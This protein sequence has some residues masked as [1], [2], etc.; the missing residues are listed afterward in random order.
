V[1]LAEFGEGEHVAHA[2]DMARA[3]L[4]SGV[5]PLAYGAE[6]G[7]EP[8][9]AGARVFVVQLRQ[10]LLLAA[11]GPGEW[12]IRAMPA[13]ATRMVQRIG[14]ISSPLLIDRAISVST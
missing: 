11:A 4:K 2:P 1:A 9:A 10:E 6:P 8:F 14:S 13:L 7:L 12:C 5:C 3:F